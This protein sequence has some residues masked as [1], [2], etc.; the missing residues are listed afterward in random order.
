MRRGGNSGVVS[1]EFAA[2]GLA[3]FMLLQIVFEVGWQ[4]ATE[5]ALEE[6]ARS[7]I[8]FAITGNATVVGAANAPACR[9]ATIVWLVTAGAPGLLQP[10]DL[11]V[12]SSAAGGPTTGSSAAGFGGGATQTVTYTFSYRQ[13]YATPMARMIL[14]GSFLTHTVVD[15]AENEP[16]PTQPC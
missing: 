10:Y 15:E 4:V 12:S 5:I 7:A 2:A 16:Y 9:A 6:G 13:P 1:V 8:R 11:L 3:L 14:G